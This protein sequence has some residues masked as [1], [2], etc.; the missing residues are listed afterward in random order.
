M[1]RHDPPCALHHE[2]H[3]KSANDEQ[4]ESRGKNPDWDKDETTTR[5]DDDRAAAAPTLRKMTKNCAAADRA[6][7]IDNS[8]DRFLVYREA[9]LRFE[10]CLIEILS[11][12]RHIIERRHEE[13]DIDENRKGAPKC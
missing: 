8:D 13:D 10:K 5:G 4:R 9:T 2:L 11:P 7:C 1:N 6:E 3:Q 12:V